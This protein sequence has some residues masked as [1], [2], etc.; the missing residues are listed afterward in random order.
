MHKNNVLRR[1]SCEFEKGQEGNL[2]MGGGTKVKRG[3]N[4]VI[5]L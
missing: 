3:E 4:Y 1:R 5:I 2:E